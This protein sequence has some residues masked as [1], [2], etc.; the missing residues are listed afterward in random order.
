MVNKVIL[1]GRVGQDPQL[2]TTNSG[3]SVANLSLA[4]SRKVQGQEQTTWHR[5]TAFGKTA[6]LC[7][8]Y[9]RKGDPIF[10][11]GE[12]QHR[13]YTDKQGVQKTSTEIL[14]QNV[15]FLGGKKQDGVPY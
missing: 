9:V 14:A 13:Q 10:V 2:N 7:A 8:Q 3:T 15:T 4:T 11:E 6:E 5:I 12:I 1:V